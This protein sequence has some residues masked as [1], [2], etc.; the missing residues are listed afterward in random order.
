MGAETCPKLKYISQAS[1]LVWLLF[2]EG[3]QNIPVIRGRH[4]VQTE[5]QHEARE[6]TCGCLIPQQF[7]GNTQLTRAFCVSLLGAS[8]G[9]LPSLWLAQNRAILKGG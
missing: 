1:R 3:A 8:E 6:S 5:Q 7:Q 4:C 9:G 2:I